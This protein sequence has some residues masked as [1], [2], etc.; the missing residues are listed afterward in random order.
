MLLILGLQVQNFINPKRGT[1]YTILYLHAWHVIVD[2]LVKSGIYSVWAS[3]VFPYYTKL[4]MLSILYYFVVKG[5]L[6]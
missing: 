4:A 6:I 3:R 1:I 2:A 5:E